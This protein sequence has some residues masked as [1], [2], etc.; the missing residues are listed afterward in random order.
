MSVEVF[1]VFANSP[2][3][4]NLTVLSLSG[5]GLDNMA[6]HLLASAAHLRRLTVLDLSHNTI[7]PSGAQALLTSSNLPCL[8]KLILVGDQQEEFAPLCRHFGARVSYTP[9]EYP[10]MEE[11][12][13]ME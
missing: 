6:T 12:G 2:R 8:R 1:E 4:S 5:L 10:A 3:L 9:F 7:H 11:D 13:E